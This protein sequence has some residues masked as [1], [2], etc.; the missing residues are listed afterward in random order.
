[1]KTITAKG[2]KKKIDKK[3][4]MILVDA[5]N[6]VEYRRRH[7]PGSVNIPYNKA[8]EK[9]KKLLPDKKKEIIIYCENERC[10]ASLIVAK[11]LI[12]LGYKNV[13]EFSGGVEGWEQAGYEFEGNSM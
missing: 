13:I 4:D 7:I 9:A 12:S 3:E 11:K 10:H 1:M 8:T 2:L 5:L 6:T